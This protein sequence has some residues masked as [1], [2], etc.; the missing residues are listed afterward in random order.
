[1]KQI[2]YVRFQILG[3]LGPIELQTT[4]LPNLIRLN[5][6]PLLHKKNMPCLQQIQQNR[7]I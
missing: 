4:P 1:M 5:K 6:I 3:H 7:L 2:T